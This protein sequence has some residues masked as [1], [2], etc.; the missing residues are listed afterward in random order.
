MPFQASDQ[1]ALLA[2]RG[3]S[4]MCSHGQVWLM[5]SRTRSPPPVTGCGRAG[6][7]GTA[8]STLQPGRVGRSHP[9]R[10]KRLRKHPDPRGVARLLYKA[11]QP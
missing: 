6:R 10:V 9:G 4:C 3:T 7:E 1:L 11:T 2:R 8:V 5:G